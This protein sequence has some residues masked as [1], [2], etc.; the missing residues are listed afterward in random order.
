MQLL[1][2]E[3]K[4]EYKFK[5]KSKLE[6]ALIHSSYANEN[7]TH[8][9]KIS[10]N[11]R[12]EFLGDAVLELVSSEF[13][14]E[15]YKDKPEGELTKI[16][17]S[18]VCEMSLADVAKSLSIGDAISLG[19]GEDKTGGRYR[20]SILSDALEAIIGAIYLDGGIDNARNFIRKFILT[21]I[22]N[23][24]LFY[25][26]KTILQERVQALQGK[27]LTYK[28]ADEFGPAHQKHFIVDV[29]INDEVV[30]QGEGGSKKAAEQDGAYKAL[31]KLNE[32][33]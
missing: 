32:K 17:A 19:K 8:K 11:E 14:F 18:L 1:D 22:E 21:D 16:R 10:D 9:E 23:R 2:L 29:C 4:I 31:L 6:T 7:S 20:N 24:H 28:L 12:L 26:S 25:D 13:L 27:V 5:D 33:G 30:A 15:K 3:S